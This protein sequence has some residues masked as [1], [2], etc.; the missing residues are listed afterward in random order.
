MTAP[1]GCVWVCLSRD[2]APVVVGACSVHAGVR[3]GVDDPQELPENWSLERL[4]FEAL[5][6]DPQGTRPRAMTT[7]QAGAE[8]RDAA[9]PASRDRRRPPRPLRRPPA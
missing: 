5:R 9:G 2:R 8:S 1:S 3:P 7:M 6:C 4:V